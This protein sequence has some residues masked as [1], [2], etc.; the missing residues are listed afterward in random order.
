VRARG[1]RDSPL[2]PG[3]SLKLR[4][5][6]PRAG[7]EAPIRC[8]RSSA[9]AAGHS[10]AAVRA[11]HVCSRA[12]PSPLPEACVPPSPCLLRGPTGGEAACRTTI[13]SANT[14]LTSPHRCADDEGSGPAGP[15][16]G[17]SRDESAGKLFGGGSASSASSG[18]P[19]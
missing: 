9:M 11:A 2:R 5:R 10:S 19:F 12:A 7:R 6:N 15:L 3:R 16:F 17:G 1:A 18:G 4:A 13:W 14:V 8:R